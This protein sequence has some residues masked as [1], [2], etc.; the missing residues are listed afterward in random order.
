VHQQRE[1]ERALGA[2][3]TKALRECSERRLS[4]RRATRRSVSP[5]NPLAAA[6]THLLALP[7]V[8]N[9]AAEPATG[10]CCE[11]SRSA[12]SP[13][14][15]Q[16]L[17]ELWFVRCVM[18]MAMAFNLR[19]AVNQHNTPVSYQSLPVKPALLPSLRL[20]TAPTS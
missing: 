6:A 7:A 3:S 12:L 19:L 20:E 16:D 8:P 5:S 17:V 13:S 14:S 9:A 18:R 2:K 1:E 15:L 10:P 11:S 4:L